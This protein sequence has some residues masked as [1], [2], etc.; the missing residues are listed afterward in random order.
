MRIHKV[1]DY[2]S[3][4]QKCFCSLETPKSSSHYFNAIFDIAILPFN[5]IIIMFQPIFAACDRNT[6]RQFGNSGE[7]FA[8]RHFVIPEFITYES[9]EFSF[10]FW[11]FSFL[12][13]PFKYLII[14]RFFNLRKK[15]NT[16]FLCS[17]DDEEMGSD[18]FCFAIY[19]IQVIM[20]FLS[21]HRDMF[22]IIMLAPFQL[23]FY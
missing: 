15:L 18:I 20:V 23:G 17:F 12:K 14:A 1:M 8:P 13:I 10:L 19:A 4:V 3:H 6:K 22:F 16:F 9:D 5:R 21:S 2:S 7:I 11:L